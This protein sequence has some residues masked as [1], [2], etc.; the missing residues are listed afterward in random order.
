MVQVKCDCK[1]CKKPILSL[2]WVNYKR[3]VHDDGIYYCNKCSWKLTGIQ[4]YKNT[5]LK[6]S[7]S[8]KQWCYD[9]LS[10]EETNKILLRWDYKLNYPNT[11]F[12]CNFFFCWN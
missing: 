2:T 11:P 12:K 3:Y 7:K 9:N 5:Q 1:D 10:K 4:N 8:F 6:N